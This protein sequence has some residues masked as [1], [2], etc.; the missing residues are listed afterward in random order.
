LQNPSEING[1]NMNNVRCEASRYS[2]NSKNNNIRDLHRRINEF[3]RGYQPG[4][5]LAKDENGD[6]LADYDNILNRWKNYFYQLL[7]L[8][9]VSDVKQVE[10]HTAEPYCCL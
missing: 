8:H 4:N 7:N 3:K 6:L 5:N 2:T 9:N 1:D 10:I